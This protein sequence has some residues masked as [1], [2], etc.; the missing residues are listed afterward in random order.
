M[1]NNFLTHFLGPHLHHQHGFLPGKGTLTAWKEIFSKGLYLKPYIREWDFKNYFNSIHNNRITEE[2]L[3]YGVPKSI[4][5]FLENINRSDIKLPMEQKL[6]ES[7]FENQ[8]MSHED[9]KNGELNEDHPS[10]KPI[11]DFIDSHP[12][13][14]ALLHEMMREDGVGSYQEYLQLQ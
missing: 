3:K 7:V 9:I 6:D 12:D 10:L 1:F 2:L 13:N 11:K 14:R 8:R 4:V 5:Y